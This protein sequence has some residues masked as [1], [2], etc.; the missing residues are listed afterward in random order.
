MHINEL[1]LCKYN[2]DLSNK[3]KTCFRFIDSSVIRLLLTSC[4]TGLLASKDNAVCNS[5][6][7]ILRHLQFFFTMITIKI[8]V[9]MI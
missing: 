6:L 1:V 7:L 8:F 4:F 3:K 2:N 9:S 5:S